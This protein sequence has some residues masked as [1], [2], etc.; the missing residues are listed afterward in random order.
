[1]NHGSPSKHRHTQWGSLAKHDHTTAHTA[2][3]S[4]ITQTA[5]HTHKLSNTSHTEITITHAKRT[6]RIQHVQTTHNPQQKEPRIYE[7]RISHT[8][9]P[10]QNTRESIRH[11]GPH[12]WHNAKY[13]TYIQSIRHSTQLIPHTTRTAH[14]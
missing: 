12:R 13:T 11:T 6:P 9:H 5:N 14:R 8:T 7:T 4:R 2:Q 3:I 10:T 1:M